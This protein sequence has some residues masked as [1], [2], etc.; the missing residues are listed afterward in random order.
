MSKRLE[1]IWMIVKGNQKAASRGISTLLAAISVW[2]MNFVNVN[3]IKNIFGF[4]RKPFPNRP[5]N[6]L[7]C[8]PVTAV[9]PVLYSNLQSDYTKF[10]YFVSFCFFR[11]RTAATRRFTKR[12]YESPCLTN[13]NSDFNNAST[14]NSAKNYSSLH[15]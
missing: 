14:R 11:T 4:L 15:S 13:G 5:A 1:T 7:R 6:L 9:R 12:R 3:L 10:L 2:H 8:S